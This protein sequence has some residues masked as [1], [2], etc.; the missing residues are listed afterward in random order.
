MICEIMKIKPTQLA[1]RLGINVRSLYSWKSVPA[2]A[3]PKIC[4]LTGL[5]PW[6]ICDEY[7]LE[8][9]KI[10]RAYHE[11]DKRKEEKKE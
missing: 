4:N 2:A 5:W 1:D 7:D 9:M 6:E 11:L 3:V 10:A 8:K